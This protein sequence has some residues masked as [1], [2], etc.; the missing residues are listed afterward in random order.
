MMRMGQ[1]HRDERRRKKHTQP[2]QAP[3]LVVLAVALLLV[4]GSWAADATAT[5]LPHFKCYQLAEKGGALNEEVTLEDQ[6]HEEQVEVKNPHFLCAPVKKTHCKDGYKEGCPPT[7]ADLD[8]FH[9]LCWK[10]APSGPPV[11]QEVTLDSQFGDTDVKVQ[12]GQLLCE[13]VHKKVHDKY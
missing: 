6:F 1:P 9:L 10:I 7:E 12:T 11:D 5:D 8:G 2:T 13:P 3:H 4:I